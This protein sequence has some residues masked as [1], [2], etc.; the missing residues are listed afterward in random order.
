M[1]GEE[2]RG[3]GAKRRSPANIAPSQ[4][5]AFS[6]RLV[7][8]LLFARCCL[9]RF[10]VA[11]TASRR[12]FVRKWA[13]GNHGDLD[14]AYTEALGS[15]KASYHKLE[16][17]KTRD[18][19]FDMRK[20][21]EEDFKKLITELIELLGTRNTRWEKLHDTSAKRGEGGS[22]RSALAQHQYIVANSAPQARSTTY[23][24]GRPERTSGARTARHRPSARFATKKSRR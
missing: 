4:L 5:V 16:R 3:R 14:I 11:N 9:C 2:W 18:N 12:R 7:A 24:T 6:T 17:E 20:L 23:T 21:S 15:T 13:C 10:L 19:Y 22:A 8:S 1:R